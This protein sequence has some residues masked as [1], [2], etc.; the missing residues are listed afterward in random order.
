[1]TKKSCRE[2][3]RNRSSFPFEVERRK[4]ELRGIGIDRVAVSNVELCHLALDHRSDS[5]QSVHCK[6]GRSGFAE[7]RITVERTSDVVVAACDGEKDVAP[8]AEHSKLPKTGT[9]D[10]GDGLARFAPLF[11]VTPH[12]EAAREGDWQEVEPARRS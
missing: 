8:L 6:E 2:R 3:R 4:N 9:L 10:K 1:M 5:V 7:R 11:A 12:R